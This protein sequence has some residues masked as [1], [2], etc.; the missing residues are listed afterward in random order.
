[1]KELDTIAIQQNPFTHTYGSAGQV[2]ID[3][4]WAKKLFQTYHLST[5]QN[6]Y[7]RS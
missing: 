6:M 5:H 3:M 4:G 1:M 2:Y 7:T